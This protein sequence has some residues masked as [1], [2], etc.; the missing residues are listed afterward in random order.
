MFTKITDHLI[1]TF[2]RA[3]VPM[4]GD[5]EAPPGFERFTDLLGWA[6]WLCLGVLIICL[7]IAGV[8]AGAGGRHGDGSEHAGRIGAVLVGVIIVTASGSLVGFLA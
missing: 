5:P 8:R 3:D 2:I 6:K 1:L 7:M 4:P